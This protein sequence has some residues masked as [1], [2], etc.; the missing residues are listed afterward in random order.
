MPAY[1]IANAE[2][3]DPASYEAYKAAVPAVI[4]QY[5]GR[6]LVRGGAAEIV[7]GGFPGPRFVVLEFPDVEAARAFA[8]S[9]E[10]AAAK[11][12]REGAADMNIAIVEGHA[13]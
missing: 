5:G 3:T 9:P 6:Y 11:A 2:V 7:E 12:R 8:R 1:V 13:P 10:Y 4:E